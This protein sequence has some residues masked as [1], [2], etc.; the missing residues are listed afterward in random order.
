MR[1]TPALRAS[2]AR[3][4]AALL[5]F[6]LATPASAQQQPPEAERQPSYYDRCFAYP[7][8]VW[9]DPVPRVYLG[10]SVS[11]PE[12]GPAPAAHAATPVGGFGGGGDGKAL[13]ALAVLAVALLPIVVWALDG[14]ADPVVVQ[15]FYCPTFGLE[16]QGGASSSPGLLPTTWVSAGRFTF[17][18]AYFGF[19]AATQFTPDSVSD[20]S[21]HL[22]LRVLPHQHLEG[23]LALGWRRAVFGSQI[24]EGAEIGLPHRYVFWRD[25]LKE[26][27]LEVRPSFTIG[28]K[29]VDPSLEMTLLVPL[30]ELLG[31]R[32]GAR[33]FSF[34][35]ELVFSASAGVFFQY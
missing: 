13:L 30:L 24:R 23:A 34:G 1:R 20:F 4:V 3:S 14:P 16:A 10:G 22:L 25:G 12:P 28:A 15:R 19:D 6:A 11:A 27:A 21:S 5:A 17:G 2:S 9:V 26:V 31:L 7:A 29:G 32:A 18:Y 35:D 33:V 8:Y